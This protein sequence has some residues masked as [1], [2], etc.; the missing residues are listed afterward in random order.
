MEEVMI[1]EYLN[2]II[3]LEEILIS[4][5]LQLLDRLHSYAGLVLMGVASAIGIG[6]IVFIG[7]ALWRL[8]R[9]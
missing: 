5:Q 4:N 9:F 3:S 7:R 2:Q 1:Y 8:V 6:V